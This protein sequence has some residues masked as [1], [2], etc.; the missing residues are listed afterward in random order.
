MWARVDVD[1]GHGA[2]GVVDGLDDGA[3]EVRGLGRGGDHRGLIAEDVQQVL[4][5]VVLVAVLHDGAQRFRPRHLNKIQEVYS[6]NVKITLGICFGVKVKTAIHS[7]PHSSQ[8][9]K[10]QSST[11]KYNKT[12]TYI[13]TPR[14]PPA[15]LIHNTHKAHKRTHTNISTDVHPMS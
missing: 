15:S 14:T 9:S 12:N 13:H 1:D 4:P 8:K 6:P 10:T 2:V 11:L 5:P 7:L 3:G